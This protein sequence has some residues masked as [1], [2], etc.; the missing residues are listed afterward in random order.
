MDVTASCVRAAV[1]HNHTMPGGYDLLHQSNQ[2]DELRS[3]LLGC[4]RILRILLWKPAKY[5]AVKVVR[6]ADRCDPGQ[7]RIDGSEYKRPVA[8][9]L[10]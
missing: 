6:K 5:G 3:Q 10:S 7:L 4:N 2:S 9:R 8:S 1:G